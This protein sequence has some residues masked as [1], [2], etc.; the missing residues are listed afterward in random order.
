MFTTID[1]VKCKTKNKF[2]LNFKIL[3]PCCLNYWPIL[4]MSVSSI[5][6]S[7]ALGHKRHA[8]AGGGK[9]GI[10]QDSRG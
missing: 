1:P 8:R 10:H 7:R 5:A 6:C 2:G 3:G 4:C 9:P